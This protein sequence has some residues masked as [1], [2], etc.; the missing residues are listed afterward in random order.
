MSADTF[1]APSVPRRDSLRSAQALR[2][3]VLLIQDD[4]DPVCQP[5]FARAL[6]AANRH[7]TLWVSQDPATVLGPWGA[8]VGA[9]RLHPRD[10]ERLVTRFLTAGKT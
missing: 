3:P 8:H 5:Q 4:R 2:Q 1:F 7:V 6:A 9:Y 10:V